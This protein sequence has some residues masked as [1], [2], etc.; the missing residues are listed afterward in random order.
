MTDQESHLNA[1]R[2]QLNNLRVFRSR[3]ASD[4]IRRQR[5]EIA[6]L[7]GEPVNEL[8][9]YLNNLNDHDLLLEEEKRLHRMALEQ[10]DA[11]KENRGFLM[12]NTRKERE[13]QPD[14]CGSINIA[15]K[16]YWISAWRDKTKAGESILN[17]SVKEK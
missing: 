10:P 13:G 2:D 17:L 1:V 15:R 16:H 9:E 14:H 4:V 7:K 5:L 6:G 12:P 11:R 8:D 3:E